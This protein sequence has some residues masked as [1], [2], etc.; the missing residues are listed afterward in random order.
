[1]YEIELKTIINC[2]CVELMRREE[3]HVI[4][5]LVIAGISVKNSKMKNLEIIGVRDSKA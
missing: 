1:M 2:C 5:P 3:D 4:G